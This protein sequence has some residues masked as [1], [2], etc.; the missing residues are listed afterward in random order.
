MSDS[1]DSS[2]PRKL[3]HRRTITAEG[4]LREDGLYDIEGWLQDVKGEDFHVGGRTTPAGAPIHRMGLRLVVDS[5]MV[6]REAE[7]R[8]VHRPYEGVCENI[9]P[10]YAELEGIQIAPGFT[11]KVRER[12]GGVRGCTHLT[13]LVSMLAT[14]A[15]QTCRPGV[16][17]DGDRVPPHLDGCH[18]LT[19]DGQVVARFYPRWR[20]FKDE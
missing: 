20:R 3:L 15:F 18:A 14:V 5:G 2:Q 8:T 16:D 12:L 4:Y 1:F 11:L 10:R 19:R 17:T 9:T 6:I 13:E 7:A